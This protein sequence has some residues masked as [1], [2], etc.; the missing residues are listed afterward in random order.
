M[1]I[2]TEYVCYDDG[3]HLKKYATN[4]CHRDLTSTTKQLAQLTIVVD[5]MHMA[6]HVDSWCKNNCNPRKFKDLDEVHV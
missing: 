1:Y 2:L 3:S 5:K 4:P 6:G